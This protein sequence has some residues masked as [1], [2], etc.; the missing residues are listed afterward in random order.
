MLEHWS[1]DKESYTKLVY[2]AITSHHKCQDAKM[3][4]LC[5]MASSRLIGSSN[6]DD[7]KTAYKVVVDPTKC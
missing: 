3:K 6:L 4:K 5:A 7:L 2:M 1:G